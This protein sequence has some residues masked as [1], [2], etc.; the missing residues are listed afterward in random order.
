M[1]LSASAVFFPVIKLLGGVALFI[2]GMDLM[3]GELQKTAGQRM[4]VFLYR[5]TSNRLSGFAVGSLL[6]LMIHSGP[7]TVMMVGL[8]NAGLM[9]FVQSIGVICGANVGTTLS[10]QIIAF[11]ID[12]YCFLVIALGLL[13]RLVSKSDAVRHLGLV[14][15]G[16]GLLFLGL[17]VMSEAVVPLKGAG[18]F[19]AVLRHSGTGSAYG[20]IGGL[21]ISALF[22]ALVQSSGATIGILFALSSAGVFTS[23]GQ[24]FPLILGAHIGTCTPAL[25]GSIGTSIL[26]RRSALAHLMYNVIGAML[27]MFTYRFYEWLM[28]LAS[29]NLLRQI[30]NTH[31]LVQVVTAGLFLPLVFPYARLISIIAP[32]RREL[33]EK[34]Y[35]DNTLLE[36]PEKAILAS[37][38]EL[39]RMASITR[40]MLREAMRG[41]L[42]INPQRFTYVSKDEEVIDTLK[43]AINS[44]LLSIAGRKLS[45]RQSIMLQFLMT[46][47]ADLERIGDHIEGIADLTRE[48]M[49][50]GIWFE[51]EAVLDLVDLFKKV[52][53][54][55]ALT[56]SSFTPSYYDAPRKLAT[57]ILE[58]RNEYVELSLRIRQKQRTELLER[59]EDAMIGIFLHRYITCFNKVVKHSKTIALVEQEPLFFLKEHKLERKSGKA[60]SSDKNG[61][62]KIALPY[63]KDLFKKK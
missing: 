59:K 27:A 61:E 9:D 21:V 23:L 20:M 48:K 6:G 4:R 39:R 11:N 10:M 45:R 51:D 16:L 35:L 53:A 41:F 43:K 30:A 42:D 49:A 13:A 14:V 31:T 25:I 2:Y 44:Y 63:D 58:M 26:A 40:E 33:P 12:R 60:D 55:L 47:T 56:T 62:P 22:T 29:G 36:T 46:A 5:L 38:K 8:I 18:F 50:K 3:S 37:L 17:S 24:V 15:L 57:R 54:I 28:P 7:T 52:D 1:I 34:T 32:S 19:E